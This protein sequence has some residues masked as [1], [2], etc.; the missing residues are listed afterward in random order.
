MSKV[1]YPH[2]LFDEQYIVSD[3]K[4]RIKVVIAFAFIVLTM[5]IIALLN[6]KG[7]S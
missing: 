2:L 3:T 6:I 1:K 7:V 4:A 5:L